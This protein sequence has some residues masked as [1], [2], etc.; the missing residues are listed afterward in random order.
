[1]N[2]RTAKMGNTD[3]LGAQAQGA[4]APASDAA[5]GAVSA[6]AMVGLLAG[7]FLSMVDSSIGN[8]ALPDIA[9]QVQSPLATA[10][11]ITSGYLLA[12]PV[13]LPAPPFLAKRLGTRGV[14][15]AR[16]SAFPLTSPPG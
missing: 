16:L 9:Q 4:P 6:W 11:W 14:F 15:F 3:P 1:M 2:T 13:V 5:Q 10:Q 12:P 7:P 8:V